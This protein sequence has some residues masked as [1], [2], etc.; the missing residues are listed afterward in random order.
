MKFAD[1]KAYYRL[2]HRR[3]KRVF[4]ELGAE[5]QK[6]V[7]WEEETRVLIEHPFFFFRQL[8]QTNEQCKLF[9]RLTNLLGKILLYLGDANMI[10]AA[11]A[12]ADA[13]VFDERR[14]LERR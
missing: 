10:V 5:L 1:C 13:N 11:I 12:L 4:V 14:E 6:M 7:E 9:S 2:T 8:Q 3:Y